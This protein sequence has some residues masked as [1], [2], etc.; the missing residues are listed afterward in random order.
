MI[1]P[2]PGE[3]VPTSNLVAQMVGRPEEGD[4]KITAAA[5]YGED[6]ASGKA[7]CPE[8]ARKCGARRKIVIIF[9][10]YT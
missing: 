9:L 1:T 8:F 5:R 6:M 4:Q 7:A 10:T 3:Y 2:V